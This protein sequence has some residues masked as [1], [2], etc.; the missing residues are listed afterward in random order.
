M[1]SRS[2]HLHTFRA[3]CLK[4]QYIA[5]QHFKLTLFKLKNSPETDRPRQ[6]LNGVAILLVVCIKQQ[7]QQCSE[8]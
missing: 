2:L 7:Q 4:D 3:G 1:E 5:P 6:S 8:H